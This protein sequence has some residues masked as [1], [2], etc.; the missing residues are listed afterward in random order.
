MSQVPRKWR[1]N[2]S[3]GPR[4]GLNT[5]GCEKKEEGGGQE[6]E[7]HIIHSRESHVRSADHEGN[8]PVSEAPNYDGHYHE[9]DYNKS[10]RCND[11]VIN[12]VV[13]KKCT[14]LAQLCSNE[15]AQR[16]PDYSGSGTKY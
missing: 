3:T 12:L 8:Q 7:A 6:P 16:R 15:Q 2:G 1:I 4:P 5:R 11:D 9:E 10:V 14:G 13:T